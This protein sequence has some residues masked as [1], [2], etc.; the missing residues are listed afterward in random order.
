[1][2]EWFLVSL[3]AC[4]TDTTTV[5]SFNA[6]F[7]ATISISLLYLP[8]THEFRS[9]SLE[10]ARRLENRFVLDRGNNNA[11]PRDVRMIF[12]IKF[13]RA[14]EREIICFVAPLVKMISRKCLAPISLPTLSREASTAAIAFCPNE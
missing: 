5:D 11:R 1:M 4:I 10:R 13:H 14:A 2:A 6:S 12:S 8:A 7:K 9:G 3:L